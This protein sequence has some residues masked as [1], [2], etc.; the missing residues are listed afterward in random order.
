MRQILTG[1]V[2]G[3]LETVASLDNA[4]KNL[5]RLA[6]ELMSLFRHL[7]VC[8][9]V[10]DPGRLLDIGEDSV[11]ALCEI[12]ALTDMEKVLRVTEI[13]AEAGERMRYA[14][15]KR[16]LL[17]TALVR[18][19]RAAGVVSIEQLLERLSRLESGDG[20]VAVAAPA[21]GVSAPPKR[22]PKPVAVPPVE[23]G[24]TVAA[25]KPAP[26]EKRVSAAVSAPVAAGA[27]GELQRQ[28]RHIAAQVGCQQLGMQ[29]ALLATAPVAIEE[30][31]LVVH[32]L[33]SA[34]AELGGGTHGR[35]VKSL[36]SM[37]SEMLDAPVTIRFEEA[38]ALP[39]MALPAPVVPVQ[40]QATEAV[41]QSAKG[42][43][44]V[45][46]LIADPS[47]QLVLDNFNGSI[48]EVREPR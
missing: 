25:R 44:T 48:T 28:W 6:S 22:K 40:E 33:A 8:L 47:V 37:V 34:Y 12:A 41:A 45:Q 43:V 18:A 42:R 16:T 4:G 10:K 35:I 7:L 46:D 36:E 11:A 23:V 26:P 27:V 20:G 3:L 32:C 30:G 15:S 2:A 38:G 5:E 19:A 29:E 9:S 17:E 1:D 21:A 24:E 13:L 14:L 39:E 31:T